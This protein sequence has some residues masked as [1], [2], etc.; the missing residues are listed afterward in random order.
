VGLDGDRLDLPNLQVR[1]IGKGNK[2]R[3]VPMGDEARERLHAYRPAR[4]P[5]GPPAGRP[6]GLRRAAR[7]AHEP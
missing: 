7:A 5:R 3:R 1:V 4:D 6:R 2:E